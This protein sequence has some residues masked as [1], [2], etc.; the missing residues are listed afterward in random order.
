MGFSWF[1][2]LPLFFCCY[3]GWRFLFLYGSVCYCTFCLKLKL[4]KHWKAKSAAKN[5]SRQAK[6]DSQV[7][8]LTGTHTHTHTL[9]AAS[10]FATCQVT[11]TTANPLQPTP[12]PLSA[13]FPAYHSDLFGCR[14]LIFCWF[15]RL[16]ALSRSTG[17]R[18]FFC[19]E[20]W[21]FWVTESGAAELMGLYEH[22]TLC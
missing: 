3:C 2:V 6:V 1:F 21:N 19:L 15:S 5:N 10:S 17:G 13:P 16:F 22:T 18:T 8:H 9:I 12:L 20:K 7:T 4:R 11:Q 14:C